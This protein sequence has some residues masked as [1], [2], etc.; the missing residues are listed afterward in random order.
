MIPLRVVV[1]LSFIN[2][3]PQIL[4]WVY[5]WTVPRPGSE[6]FEFWI[7]KPF[8]DWLC[9][10]AGSMHCHPEIQLDHCIGE[11]WCKSLFHFIIDASIHGWYHVI[12]PKIINSWSLACHAAW[13]LWFV[14]KGS[15]KVVLKIMFFYKISSI[16]RCPITFVKNEN[17][18]CKL[19]PPKTKII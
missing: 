14:Q 4:N 18:H 2:F 6:V 13:I 5:V 16:S 1:A 19:L 12:T 8:L 3:R 10:V 9:S 15:D 17:L 11:L 7:R